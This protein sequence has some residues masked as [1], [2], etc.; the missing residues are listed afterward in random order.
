MPREVCIMTLQKDKMDEEAAEEVHDGTVYRAIAGVQA[1]F[2]MPDPI[3]A[4]IFPLT[5]AQPRAECENCCALQPPWLLLRSVSRR[6]DRR[7]RP[8]VQSTRTQSRT[9]VRKPLALHTCLMVLC[10]TARCSR[11]LCIVR[12]VSQLWHS[13]TFRAADMIVACLAHARLPVVVRILSCAGATL[14]R[15]EAALTERRDVSDF[16]GVL[17]LQG[18]GLA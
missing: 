13:V 12:T 2:E 15:I 14:Q 17:T 5:R 18:V 4:A 16:P 9:W 8:R 10:I 7:L 11:C 1:P 6:W 3:C